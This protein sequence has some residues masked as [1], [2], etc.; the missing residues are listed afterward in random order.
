MAVDREFRGLSHKLPVMWAI[1]VLVA[2]NQNKLLNKQSGKKS[3]NAVESGWHPIT[4]T[5]WKSVKH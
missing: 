2:D 4:E 1:H 5:V 3:V